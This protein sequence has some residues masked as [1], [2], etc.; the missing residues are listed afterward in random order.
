MAIIN[1]T[2]G[3]D[4]D[5]DGTAEADEIN[6]FAGND[7]LDGRDGNDTLIG[8]NDNDTI[9]GEDG[10]D[11]VRGGPGS[12][13]LFGG[14][15]AGF[16]ID[17]DTRIGDAGNDVL[18]AGTGKDT[19]NGG[20]ENDILVG[21]DGND[22]LSG[23]PGDD[24]LRG[25]EG[26]DILSGNTGADEFQFFDRFSVD[27]FYDTGVGNNRDVILDFDGTEGDRI[28]VRDIDADVTN[29]GPQ[30]GLPDDAFIFVGV[31]PV[32]T[33]EI[34]FFETTNRTIV[35]ANTDNDAAPEFEIQLDGIG[36]DLSAD[37]F[38]L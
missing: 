3:D 19:L 11:F 4:P 13:Q 15:P 23:G 8:G 2:P 34:G 6:G 33:G 10:N 29:N 31:E 17:D 28:R 27:V 1:G 32:G 38:L 16:V 35:R 30:P 24:D 36:H 5:L 37:D 14:A 21:E 12:D 25:D 7:D 9:N 20:A 26:R 22:R 18:F